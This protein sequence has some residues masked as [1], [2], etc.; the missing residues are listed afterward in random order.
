MNY[1]EIVSKLKANNQEHIIKAYDRADEKTKEILMEQIK[2]IDFKQVA[3]LFKKTKEE[4]NFSDDVIDPIEYV[5]KEKISE[6]EYNKYLSL[7]E[8]AIKAGKYSVV[9]MAGGQ[10]TRL[11]HT[12]PKG[13]YDIGL[14]SHKSIFEILIDS[15]KDDCKKYNVTIPWYIMTG[16]EN[17]DDTIKFFED[18]NYF[19]YDK[20]YIKFFQQGKLPMCDE[21]GKILINEKGIIKEA[22][23]GHGGIFQSMKKN[24]IVDDMKARGIEWAF[25]GPVDNVLVK[26]V[27]PVLLGVMIN[28]KVL[29]GG[30]S[31]VKANASEKV[32]VFCKRNGKP[33]VIEYTE[34]SKEMAERVN[35][36]GELVFAESHLNC[37]MFNVKTIEE[38]AE[39]NLPYH[40]AHKKASYIDENGNLIVPEKPNAYKFESFI[41]DAFDMLDDMA[42]LRVKR[43]EE[44]APVKNAEGTDSPETARK[45]YEDF[46]NIK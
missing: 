39:K 10:G 25:I 29:A 20:S 32:G 17:N 1:D 28:N 8:E 12:G 24:G 44:F 30:K 4:T 21:S 42:I 46:Y 3:D 13:T 26:M 18:N 6:E 2:R 33:G 38:V 45:L 11:G 27:D 43:E 5:D 15:I 35:E 14:D 34:I 40:I 22:A 37:N 36:K 23:D 19:G 7:G 31:T 16:K 41:F 9:T